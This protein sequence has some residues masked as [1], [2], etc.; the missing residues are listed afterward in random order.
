MTYYIRYHARSGHYTYLTNNSSLLSKMSNKNVL[1]FTSVQAAHNYITSSLNDE[2]RQKILANHSADNFSVFNADTNQDIPITFSK[3]QKE[4]LNEIQFDNLADLVKFLQASGNNTLVLD[5][6]FYNNKATPNTDDVR[7]QQIAGIMLDDPDS[8]FDYFTFEPDYMS[9]K[10]QVQFLKRVNEPYSEAMSYTPE[11]VM[12][13]VK[14]FIE[15]HGVQTILS[16]GN[17]T[18]FKVLRQEDVFDTFDNLQAL[19]VEKT[20]SKVTMPTATKDTVMPSLNLQAIC[21]ILGLK[22]PDPYHDA[23][24]DSNMIRRLCHVYMDKLNVE[25]T[26]GKDN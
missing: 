22:N 5:L 23:L 18:D 13:F 25:Q 24:S 17:N 10:D 15:D 1:N 3:T 26:L 14:K 12:Q 19:D 6:E 7:M 9:F 11:L 21:E 16:W 4:P 2:K 8:Y 20:I